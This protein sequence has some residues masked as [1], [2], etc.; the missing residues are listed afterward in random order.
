LQVLLATIGGIPYGHTQTGTAT[1]T[2]MGPTSN[3]ALTGL[4]GLS[5]L[6][7]LTGT[8]GGLFGAPA[9]LKGIL[10]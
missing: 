9:P 5:S 1:Q 2:G 8:I 6:A 7:S 3:P 4:G 10:G